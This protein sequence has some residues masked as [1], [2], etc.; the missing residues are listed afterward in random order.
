[1]IVRCSECNTAYAVDDHKIE[2]KKFAFNCPKCGTNVV[3]DNRLKTEHGEDL[4]KTAAAPRAKTAVREDLTQKEAAPVKSKPSPDLDI[5]KE[6]LTDEELLKSSE[7]ESLKVDDFDM[8]LDLGQPEKTA[9]K[10]ESSDTAEGLDESGILEDFDEK[11]KKKSTAPAPS[12][13]PEEFKPADEDVNF[14]DILVYDTPKK[15]KQKTDISPLE[16][17][18]EKD[19]NLGLTEDLILDTEVKSDEIFS[20]DSSDIDESVTIDLDSLDIELDETAVKK[21]AEVDQSMDFS[22]IIEDETIKKPVKPAKAAKFEE[23]SDTTIDLDSLDITL[24]EVE[25]LKKGVP[26]DEDERLTL[27]DAGLNID[28]L[29]SE[30]KKSS[31]L[32]LLAEETPDEDIKLNIK[33][34]DPSLSVE[35]LSKEMEAGDKLLIDEIESEKLPEIDLDTFQEENVI[36]KKTSVSSVKGATDKSLYSDLLDIDKEE[37]SKDQ[38]LEEGKWHKGSDIVPW[39]CIN[40]SI[41][42]TL[43]YSRPGAILRLSG[44]YLIKLIPHFVVYLLYSFLSGIL[45]FFNW[46]SCLFT[47]YTNMDFTEIQENTLRYLISIMACMTDIIEETPAYAGKTSIDHPLQISFTYP[48]RYSKVL[49]FLRLSFI[50]MIIIMIPHLFI[51]LLLS[52]GAMLI[53]LIGIISVIITRRWPKIIFDFMVKYFAYISN[54][55]AFMNGIIDRYPSFRLE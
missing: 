37:Y 39:G 25:E 6:S 18:E 47:G 52:I 1:M 31:D 33:E 53:Y 22:D 41:D 27:E 11:P 10:S 9:K 38:I 2:N 49:A 13:E 28:E 8:G 20:K 54:V 30:D 46:I 19:K 45:G 7:D 29:S 55:L 17:E 23:E 12:A 44:L 35:D 14:D 21:P 50:G 24:D 15:G 48:V 4:L 3:I 43:S 34:I 5:E 42:Y 26:V 40:F 32:D 51:L 16:L 36:D